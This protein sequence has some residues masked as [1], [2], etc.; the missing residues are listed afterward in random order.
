M[1]A[2]QQFDI[3]PKSHIEPRNENKDTR[4]EKQERNEYARCGE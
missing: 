2:L 4:D 1:A 3:S